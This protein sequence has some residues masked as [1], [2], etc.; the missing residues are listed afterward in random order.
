[1]IR[2]ADDVARRPKSGR[3]QPVVIT[4]L[5]SSSQAVDDALRR[6]NDAGVPRDLVDVVVSPEAAHRF[7]PG[8]AR[9]PGREVF[10]F[11]AIGGLIGLILS[12]LLS[13]AIIAM[14]GFE[15]PGVTA[16]VQLLGPNIGTVAGA[17]LGGLLAASRHRR[18]S[19]RLAGAAEQSSAILLAVCTPSREDVEPLGRILTAAGGRDVR[20]EP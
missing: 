15:S 8:V 6:L 13:F 14:P 18:P 16:V 17:A 12:A 2:A 4:A 3:P 20:I 9:S 10:R 1:M 5:M 7:Y 19:R 11:A